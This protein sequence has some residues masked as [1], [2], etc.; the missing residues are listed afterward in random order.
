MKCVHCQGKM[1]HGTAPF[2]VDRKGYHLVLEAVPAWVC[3]QC[4]EV[5]FDEREVDEIQDVIQAVDQRTEK[6]ATTA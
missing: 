3:S 1:E 5:Y 6:M 4:G 2:Q